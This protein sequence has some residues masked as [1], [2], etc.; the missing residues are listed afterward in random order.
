MFATPCSRYPG[1]RLHSS[2]IVGEH[3][4]LDAIEGRTEGDGPGRGTDDD[5]DSV[6]RLRAAGPVAD[7]GRHG[8]SLAQSLAHGVASDA[9]VAPAINTDGGGSVIVSL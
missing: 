8:V 1:R 3:D 2:W 6:G 5:F 7:K 4:R 9:P